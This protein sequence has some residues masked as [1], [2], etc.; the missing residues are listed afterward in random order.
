MQHIAPVPDPHIS[1]SPA[2]Q[3]FAHSKPLDPCLGEELMAN[4]PS[5][6]IANHLIESYFAGADYSWTPPMTREEVSSA[7]LAVYSAT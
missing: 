1:L 4:L 2:L 7:L 5:L 3:S 6:E